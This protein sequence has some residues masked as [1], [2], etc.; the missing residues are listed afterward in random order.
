MLSKLAFLVIFATVEMMF[1][2]EDFEIWH[3]EQTERTMRDKWGVLRE[4]L[5]PVLGPGKLIRGTDV[6]Q[7]RLVFHP[8]K[9]RNSLAQEQPERDP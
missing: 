1:V 9:F 3:T 2:P 7:G 6:E 8:R 4:Y 5:E